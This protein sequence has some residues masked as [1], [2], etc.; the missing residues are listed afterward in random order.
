MLVNG[1][2]EVNDGTNE[3]KAVGET[4]IDER[5]VTDNRARQNKNKVKKGKKERW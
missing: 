4:T 5:N 2:K 1:N 3:T